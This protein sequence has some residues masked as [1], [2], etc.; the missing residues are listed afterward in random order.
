MNKILIVLV[1]LCNRFSAL[2]ASMAVKLMG[3][4]QNEG[5][6]KRAVQVLTPLFEQYFTIKNPVVRY[7]RQN[8]CSSHIRRHCYSEKY[9][10]EQNTQEK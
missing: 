6:K 3:Y 7:G 10:N 2:F 5:L 4:V 8:S 9:S 1:G